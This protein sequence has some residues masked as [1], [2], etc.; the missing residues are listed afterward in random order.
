MNIFK[1]II[2]H[3]VV[4]EGPYCYK[5]LG[6][7]PPPTIGIRTKVCPFWSCF[8]DHDDPSAHCSLLN[9][10]DAD[11]LADQCKICGINEGEENEDL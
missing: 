9:E 6:V 1:R 3:F 4:P 2:A 5:S 10:S 11:L 7:L 8:P